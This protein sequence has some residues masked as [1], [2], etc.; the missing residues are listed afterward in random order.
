MEPGCFLSFV[1]ASFE[2]SEVYGPFGI[3]IEVKT[4]VKSYGEKSL[5]NV[6]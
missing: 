1:E 2:S 4:L 6:R 5:R 3:P